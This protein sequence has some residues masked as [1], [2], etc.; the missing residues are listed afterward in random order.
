MAQA[1]SIS[2][3]YGNDLDLDQVIDLYRRSTLG[4]R[5]P[6]DDRAAMQAMIEHANLVV[7]AWHGE[8]MVGIAR[9]LTDFVYTCY[10]S[11]LAVDVAYQRQGIGIMLIQKTRQKLGP[12]AKI[13]LLAAPAAVEY[14]PHI[15]FTKHNSA[16]MLD[17]RGPFPRPKKSDG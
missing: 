12:H 6:V 17:T 3:R 15:G 1:A 2:Y 13:I 11:D 4:A 9:S 16:W 5:R 10:L 14:Y 8:T 7:T